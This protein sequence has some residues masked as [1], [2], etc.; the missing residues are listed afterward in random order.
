MNRNTFKLSLVLFLS[1]LIVGCLPPPKID[2]FK[3]ISANETAFVIPLEGNT[4]SQ[5]KF[6][7]VKYL[8]QQK[9]ATK[10]IYLPQKKVKT[11]RWWFNCKWIPTV[12]VITV[13]RK[14]IRLIWEG[15]SRHGGNGIKV[16]SRDSIGFTVGIDITAHVDEQDTATFLYWFP[17]GDL[18]KVLG[19]V[20][21]SSATE[22]LSREF[23]K[24]NL[25]G[26]P[27][28]YSKTGKLI[29]KALIGARERKG[30]IVDIA[31]KE[32]TE[33]FK[34]RG[35]TIDTFGLVGGLEYENREIQ[36]AINRNFKS[37]LEIENR[38]NERIAQDEINHKLIDQADAEQKAAEKFAKAADA[39]KK[40]IQLEIDMINAK[41]RKAWAERW[42]G[43]LP[44]KI[45]PS[46]SPLMFSLN[47]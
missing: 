17:N 37:A 24:Y 14:P 33:H 13:D 19:A 34:A 16:E 42:N 27:A 2:K 12:K 15:S 23:A 9:V 41:A 29:R 10:R 1:I 18:V 20:V 31:K 39:R 4:A 36:R 22:I 35:V 26:T 47:K 3:D 11:G 25:E 21:K 40:Q 32:L 8:E 43:V 46:N 28:L 45:I 7:S 30:E 5:G 6:A 38:K 44:D